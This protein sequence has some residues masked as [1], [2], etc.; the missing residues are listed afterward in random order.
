MFEKIEKENLFSH[1]VCLSVR[2]RHKCNINEI[3]I[4]SDLNLIFRI[5][6]YIYAYFWIKKSDLYNKFNQFELFQ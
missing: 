6:T 4:E 2:K 5:T 1:V 3:K